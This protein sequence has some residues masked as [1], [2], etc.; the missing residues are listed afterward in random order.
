M[1]AVCVALVVFATAVQVLHRCTALEL[2]GSSEPGSAPVY[3]VVCMT[4]QVAALA[5]AAVVFAITSLAPVEATPCTE[6][7]PDL[8]PCFALY[9]R[10]PPTL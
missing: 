10:P 6:A 7:V 1:A 4:A 5:V 8:A 3:C 2:S 9:V